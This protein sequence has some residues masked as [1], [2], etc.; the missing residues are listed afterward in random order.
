MRDGLSEAQNINDLSVHAKLS[1]GVE[2]LMGTS[3]DHIEDSVAVFKMSYSGTAPVV[4]VVRVDG[5]EE[6]APPDPNAAA[7]L[8]AMRHNTIQF[9]AP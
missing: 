8:F 3:Q 5:F 6:S 4:T 2:L 7:T 9:L 1:T